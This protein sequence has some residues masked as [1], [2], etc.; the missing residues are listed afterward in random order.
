MEMQWGR[1]DNLGPGSEGSKRQQQAPRSR[2]RG[3]TTAGG[4]AAMPCLAMEFRGA[5]GG[6]V[7]ARRAEGMLRWAEDPQ[8]QGECIS[9]DKVR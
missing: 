5:W 9:L 6:Q 3:A 2:G 7:S 1:E 4:H 8:L